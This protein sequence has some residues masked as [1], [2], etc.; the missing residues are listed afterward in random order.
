MSRSQSHAS[1]RTRYAVVS[2]SIVG[3]AV[4]VL[5]AV[6][7]LF[8]ISRA[9]DISLQANHGHVLVGVIHKPSFD[10]TTTKRDRIVF[11]SFDSGHT[12]SA[13]IRTKYTAGVNNS[14]SL[15]SAPEGYYFY[16][17]VASDRAVS[18]L[19][20]DKNTVSS[21]DI[22]EI[23]SGV[24]NYIGD[25]DLDADY[26]R[27]HKRGRPDVSYKPATLQKSLAHFP[28]YLNT[29]EISVS[30]RGKEATSLSV[31]SGI[32]EQNPDSVPD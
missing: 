6:S 1:R 22:F 12:F 27:R 20:F 31:L 11:K 5:L 21:D 29:Y 2:R 17:Y 16:S 13:R 25:W 30:M 26:Y 24:V 3:L 23:K 32:Q 7:T 14:L 19:P 10:T 18:N 8:T 28:E 4:I 9:D 15:L